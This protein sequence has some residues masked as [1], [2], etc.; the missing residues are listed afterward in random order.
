MIILGDF[1]NGINNLG[2]YGV[3]FW[4]EYFIIVYLVYHFIIIK[5]YR[6]LHYGDRYIHYHI[7]DTGS[8]G[9]AI[10]SPSNEFRDSD[11][12]KRIYDK[13]CVNRGTLF[14]NFENVQ[15]LSINEDKEKTTYYCDRQEF[16]V[17]TENKLLEQLYLTFNNQTINIMLLLIILSLIIAAGTL[18]FSVSNFSDINN[19]VTQMYNLVNSTRP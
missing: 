6:K 13:E 15:P 19:K 3:M 11:G 5:L 10:V 8:H 7:I 9:N 12:I 4:I 18:Y 1:G 2:F 16:L 17:V 14:Y